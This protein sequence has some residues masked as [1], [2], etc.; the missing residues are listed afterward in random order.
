M[1]TLEDK[2]DCLENCAGVSEETL[3]IVTDV[4]GYNDSTLDDVLYSM[5]G[6]RD[7]EDIPEEELHH[8]CGR[9]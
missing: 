4:A 9:G 8:S 3:R 2:W 1:F 5:I 6:H 7:F